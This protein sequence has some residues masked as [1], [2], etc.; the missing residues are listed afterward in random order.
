M[1]SLALQ[2]PNQ[3]PWA[4]NGKTLAAIV[5][6]IHGRPDLI[7]SRVDPGRIVLAGHSFGAAAVAIALAEGAPAA[8]AVLLDPA[9]IGKELPPYLRRINKP[10]LVV[11]ADEYVSRVRDRHLFYEVI[12][13]GVADVSIRDAH[14]DDAEFPMEPADESHATEALQITFV[15]ALT[16]AAF[17]LGFT[18][19]LDYAWTSFGAAIQNGRLFDALRK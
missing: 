15:S 11:G 3:G 5:K 9:G 4:A 14:H 19:G 16:S 2:L 7:D 8:G 13:R 17:S 1:H 18:G 6:L 12:R 10:V